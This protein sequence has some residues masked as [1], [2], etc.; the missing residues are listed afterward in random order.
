MGNGYHGALVL[1]QMGFQPLD[2]FC[3]Q[4]VGRLVKEKDVRLPQKQ[5]AKRH[6]PP[7][8]SGQSRDQGL[9]RR[10]VQSVHRPFQL[11]IQFPSAHVVDHLREFTLA[12]DEGVHLIVAHRLHELHRDLIVFIQDIHDL[13]DSFL[14][15]FKHGLGRIHLRFLLEVSHRIPR[16]PNDFTLVRFLDSGDDLQEGGFSRTVQTDDTDLGA[17]EERKVDVLQDH[18]VVVRES[19]PYPAHRK[20]NGLVC[21]IVWN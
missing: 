2:A 14:H 16:S 13:L 18:L 15:N 11:R 10:T 19:L 21:H 4:V 8:S 3:V 6:P 7:F 12:L 1:P 9:L 17:I 20:D 5:A